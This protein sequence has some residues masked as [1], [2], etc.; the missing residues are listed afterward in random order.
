M[1]GQDATERG[2]SARPP[3]VT[4]ART[5]PGSRA[6]PGLDAL[7]AARVRSPD[8]IGVEVGAGVAWRTLFARA[9]YQAPARWDLEGRPID[10]AGMALTAGYR[11]AV[12]ERDA[13][14]IGLVLAAT[15]E[16]VTVQR[17][18]LQGAAVHG[19]WDPGVVV[20]GAFSFDLAG[21][22]GL[23]MQVE[24]CRL[25]GRTVRVPEGPEAAF[26]HLGARAALSLVWTP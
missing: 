4:A 19:H 7:V 9:S 2:S 12:Y 25:V 13:W 24:G 20:G 6:W 1:S 21:G 11:P 8:T 15:L 18:D 22:L 26:N 10:V 17:M 5:R 3:T 23:T 14:R 16:R